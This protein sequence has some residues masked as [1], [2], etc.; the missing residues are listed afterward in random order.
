MIQEKEYHGGGGFGDTRMTIMTTAMIDKQDVVKGAIR[1][2][3]N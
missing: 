1:S 2:K 3:K